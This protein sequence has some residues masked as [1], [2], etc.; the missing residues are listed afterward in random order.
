MQPGSIRVSGILRSLE[1]VKY[2]QYSITRRQQVLQGLHIAVMLSLFVGFTS[3]AE[4]FATFIFRG[5]M[6]N[7]SHEWQRRL[8]SQ[9]LFPFP[10]FNL[11]LEKHD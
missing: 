8:L 1:I 9:T 10:C 7:S 6:M 4:V 3:F 5:G 2:V 11:W